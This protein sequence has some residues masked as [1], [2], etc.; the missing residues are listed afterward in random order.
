MGQGMEGAMCG[1]CGGGIID[2]VVTEFGAVAAVCLLVVN[3]PLEK[4]GDETYG[5]A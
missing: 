4:T 5:L 2:W 3:V 1:G